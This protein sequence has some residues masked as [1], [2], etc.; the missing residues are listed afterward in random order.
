MRTIPRTRWQGAPLAWR[1]LRS[2]A[3]RCAAAPHLRRCRSP[4]PLHLARV[5]AQALSSSA[6][7]R[8]TIARIS[9][10]VPLMRRRFLVLVGFADGAPCCCERHIVE[11]W[12][13]P[14][15]G[16]V[17]RRSSQLSSSGDGRLRLCRCRRAVRLVHGCS[18]GGWTCS[19]RLATSG[20]VT[21]IGRTHVRIARVGAEGACGAVGTDPAG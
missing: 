9:E 14:G 4:M 15:G 12:W 6:Q 1:A 20:C 17:R 16:R 10:I 2:S 5:A 3:H 11:W 8:C 21:K 13:V 7:P 18:G 19:A